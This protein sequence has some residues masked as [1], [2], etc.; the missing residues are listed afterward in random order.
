MLTHMLTY[1]RLSSACDI[2]ARR[3][4]C[5][6]KVLAYEYK[7]TCV[8]VQKYLLTSTKVQILTSR[9]VVARLDVQG[10]SK[11]E[12]RGDKEKADEKQV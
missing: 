1:I 12:S 3:T 5:A 6:S 4:K 9:S 8:L 11:R 7:S 2:G 10:G